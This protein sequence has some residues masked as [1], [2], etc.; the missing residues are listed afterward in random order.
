MIITYEHVHTGVNF[1]WTCGAV[2]LRDPEATV[3]RLARDYG[4]KWAPVSVWGC[5][6][7]VCVFLH[8]GSTA[9]HTY[10]GFWACQSAF[11]HTAFEP[12]FLGL[13]MLSPWEWETV[14]SSLQVGGSWLPQGLLPHTHLMQGE[15]GD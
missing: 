4:N 12:L 10:A 13:Q 5:T 1:L 6:S 3:V 7:M 11:E 9:V 8:E 15:A 14:C 2:R